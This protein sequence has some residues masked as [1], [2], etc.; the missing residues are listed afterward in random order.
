MKRSLLAAV[1]ATAAL[2]AA[3]V[4]AKDVVP[5]QPKAST[6]GAALL[7]ALTTTQVVTVVTLVTATVGAAAIRESGGSNNTQ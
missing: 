2:A 3:P 6:Q 4:M 1:A 5:V 7:G